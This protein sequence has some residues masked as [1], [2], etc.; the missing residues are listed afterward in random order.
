MRCHA[1]CERVGIG[2]TG[3]GGIVFFGVQQ[4]AKTNKMIHSCFFISK[5]VVARQR[6]HY[7]PEAGT[8]YFGIHKLLFRHF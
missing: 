1:N 4:N 6:L 8:L 2:K 7:L 5:E 3:D